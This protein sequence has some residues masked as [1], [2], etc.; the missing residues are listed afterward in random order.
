[1][2]R[3]FNFTALTF[4]LLFTATIASAKNMPA[5]GSYT[6]D[7][8]HS[9]VGFSIAHLVIATVEGRFN[10]FS[11]NVIA[12]P[13][14]QDSQVEVT[15]QLASIDT[16][17]DKRDDHLRSPDFFDVKKYPTMT[18]KS[19]KIKGKGKKFE[20]TGDLNLHGVTKPVTFKGEYLG[21]VK[22]G[23]G[24]EKAAFRAKGELN[25]SD[26]GIKY[27]SMVEAGPM[28][29]EK[30]TIDLIV[31]ATKDKKEEAAATKEDAKKDKK[32]ESK[33]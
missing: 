16:G 13:K 3:F 32:S 1:M 28:I 10:E 23:W 30:V 18:F 11:G 7:P 4:A 9:K 21:T 26:Y 5:E 14:W 27:N 22:D 19:T 24:N 8:A 6:I 2:N 33:K 15:V 20:M 25:R 12:G 29:G 17:V 31:Q